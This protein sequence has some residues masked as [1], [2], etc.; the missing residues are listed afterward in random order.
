MYVIVVG[1]VGN[2]VEKLQKESYI[3]VFD[4]AKMT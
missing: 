2:I 3:N 1:Y 4:R